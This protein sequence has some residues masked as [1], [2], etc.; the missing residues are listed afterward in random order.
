MFEPIDGGIR[1]SHGKKK[2][3]EDRSETI[4]H[5]VFAKYRTQMADLWGSVAQIASKIKQNGRQKE[6]ARALLRARLVVE[7]EPGSKP[8]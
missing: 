6:I 7:P 8:N 1:F 4:N 5:D 3:V 2:L